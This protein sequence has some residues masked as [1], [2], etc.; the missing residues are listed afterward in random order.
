M[1]CHYEVLG[2]ERSAGDE[3]IKKAYRK[4]ALR[5]H[6]DKNLDNTEKA[7]QQFLLVQAAYDV[8][9]DIQERAWYDNHREQILRGG[10]TNYEDNSIDLFQYFTASCYK[11][12]GDDPGG[13]YAV[14][15]E[16]FNTIASEEIEFLDREE[17]FETIPKFGNSAS[18]YETDVRLFYG[19]WECFLTKKSYAWLNPHNISEIRDRRILKVIEKENKKIQQKA[20]KE[21]NEEIRSLVMFVKK[22]DK[23]VQGYKKLLEER[24][25]QNRIKSQQ[26]RLE[27]IRR[28][29]KEIEEQ[30]KNSSNIFNEAYEEQLRKLEESYADAS[31][32][33]ADENEEA[34]ETMRDAMNGLM[35]SQDENGEE[36]FYVDDLYCVA[37]DK[38]FNNK[39]TYENHESSKKHK[40]NVELLK[41]QM[42]KEE[43]DSELLDDQRS[44]TGDDPIEKESEDEEEIAVQKSSK[45][46]NKKKATK[47]R[48]PS[49]NEES[50]VDFLSSGVPKIVDSDDDWS[51]AKKTKKGKAKAKDSGQNKTKEITNPIKD[52]ASKEE[53]GS[54]LEVEVGNN[55]DDADRN[56]TTDHKCVTCNEKFTSKNKLFNHLKQ[57]GHSVYINKQKPQK[58]DSERSKGGKSGNKR[59]K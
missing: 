48:L 20:R 26:N 38:M 47:M 18:N 2:V 35:I 58:A 19:F 56:G 51:G 52:T 28:K 44:Q 4:L 16:V 42:R 13:F 49:E 7:N 43:E 3:E 25:E 1:K 50:H 22:R 36:H 30:Q 6:P 24:A 53:S 9:S 15:G 39:K 45:G 37:C 27:Q 17:D 11:G 40:Q 29:Q 32:S 54:Q 59:N 55:D 21:R 57:T 5:W 41:K 46:K 34:A 14:Y 8:L 23:R 10:H 12:F 33:S 31:E